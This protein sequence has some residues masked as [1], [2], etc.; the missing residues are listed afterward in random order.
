MKRQGSKSTKVDCT[1]ECNQVV[2]T[3]TDLVENEPIQH[4]ED[5]E[6]VISRTLYSAIVS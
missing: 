6:V 3:N 5:Q 4:C 2:Q 1:I